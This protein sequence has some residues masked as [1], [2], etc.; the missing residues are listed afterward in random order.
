M[1]WLW[2]SN[3]SWRLRPV[4]VGWVCINIVCLELFGWRLARSKDTRLFSDLPAGPRTDSL[5]ANPFGLF[6]YGRIIPVCGHDRCKKVPATGGPSNAEGCGVFP[7]CHGSIGYHLQA[8][9]LRSNSRVFHKLIPNIIRMRTIW[10][11]IFLHWG[12]LRHE[13]YNKYGSKRRGHSTR[14][15]GRRSSFPSCPYGLSDSLSPF[16]STRRPIG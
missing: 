15:V 3:F 16:Y 9:L 8:L 2:S 5:V 14:G 12:I 11:H 1:T 6:L 10:R 13:E 4:V 7:A